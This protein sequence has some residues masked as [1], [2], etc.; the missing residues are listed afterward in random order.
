QHLHPSVERHLGELIVTRSIRQVAPQ[1]VRHFSRFVR[2][3]GRRVEKLARYR[4]RGYLAPCKF[5]RGKGLIPRAVPEKPRQS[6][7]VRIGHFKETPAHQEQPL[8]GQLNRISLSGETRSLHKPKSRVE[9][10]LTRVLTSN[11]IV[12]LT[13]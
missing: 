13:R 10:H 3:S 12:M 4:Q 8:A 5:I 7:Q 2:P 1:C 9:A 6:E 11:S